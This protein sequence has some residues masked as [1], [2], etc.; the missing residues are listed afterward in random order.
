MARARPA[1]DRLL[2]VVLVGQLP[3]AKLKACPPQLGW[4]YV[5]KKYSIKKGTTWEGVKK[6]AIDRL[7]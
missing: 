6:E 2:K 7:G 3:R 1:D 5:V 4:K